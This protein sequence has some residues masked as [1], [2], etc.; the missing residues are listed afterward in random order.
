MRYFYLNILILLFA[1]EIAAQTYS[2]SGRI[3]D[4]ENKPL[5]G[6]NII[7]TGTATGTSSDENG[8]YKIRNLPNGNYRIRYSAVG[9]GDVVRN[10]LINNNPVYLN[11]IMV[12]KAVETQQVIVTAGKREQYISDLPVSADVIHSDE[13]SK[14]NFS[15]LENAL[16]YVPGV[17][18]TE[19]QISIRGSSGYSRG[20]GSRVLLALDGIPFYTGDTGE[21]IWEM[22]PTPVIKRVEIIKGAA[23]SLYGSTAIGGVI[24]VITNDIPEK[25]LTFIKSY[26]GTYSNP[27]FSEWKWSG[28][29]RYFNGLTIAHAQNFGLFGIEVSLTRLGDMS[30]RQSGFSHKYSH[31]PGKYIEQKRRELLLLEGF[32]TCPD[33]Y[34]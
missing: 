10:V 29:N 18:M 20:A 8:E 16:R 2:V 19:D 1:V 15:N 26:I 33:P 11:I 24:N 14:K 32:E 3:T 6:V 28:E 4:T 13:F 21:T 22:I 9:Y 27:S 17:N 34:R 12:E 23:S 5:V 30:Y 25:P 7:V 31:H